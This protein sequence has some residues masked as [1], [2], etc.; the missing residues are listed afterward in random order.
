MSFFKKKYFKF[1]NY[2]IKQFEIKNL[3]SFWQQDIE[4]DI[5][6]QS[7]LEGYHKQL[8]SLFTDGP[9]PDVPNF[10]NTIFQKD[11][12]E[13]AELD[14]LREKSQGKEYS[15]KNSFNNRKEICKSTISKC[16]GNIYD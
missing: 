9:G 7:A 12:K 2:F 1:I 8:K 10:I 14:Y 16:I 5:R 13:I 15:L 4:Q 3:Q 11:I 6:T